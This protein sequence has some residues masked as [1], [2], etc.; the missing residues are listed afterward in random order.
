MKVPRQEIAREGIDSDCLAASS[1][2]SHT[3]RL[4]R[5]LLLVS[6]MKPCQVLRTDHGR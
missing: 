4:G 3:P 1:V 6:W 5:P 2:E